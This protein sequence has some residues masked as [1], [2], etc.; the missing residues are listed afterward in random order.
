[1][2]NLVMQSLDA[3]PPKVAEPVTPPIEDDRRSSED[4]ISAAEEAKKAT[5]AFRRSDLLPFQIGAN[6]KDF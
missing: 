2:A 1:M 6:K 5:E 3:S 4:S